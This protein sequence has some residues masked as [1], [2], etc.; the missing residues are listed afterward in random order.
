MSI[1]LNFVAVLVS[2]IV[3][4]SA[5]ATEGEALASDHGCLNCHYA[6]SH[7]S[8]TLER[9]AGRASRKGDS[10][11]NLQHL[12]GEMRSHD[13][14]HSHLMVSDES[15]LAVLKWMAQGAK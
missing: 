4:A 13:K 11:D 12:L 10:A 8:P 9:L 3:G 14:V 6:A 7:S 15:A 1:R 5:S 2:A